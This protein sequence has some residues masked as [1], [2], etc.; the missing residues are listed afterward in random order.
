MATKA[1]RKASAAKKLGKVKKLQ[2]T[3]PLFSFGAS[4]HKD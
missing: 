3:K 1:K 2:S 4:T